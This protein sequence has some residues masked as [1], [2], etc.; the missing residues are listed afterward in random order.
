MLVCSR[1]A[2]AEGKFSDTRPAALS[3]S[4]LTMQVT[5]QDQQ[6]NEGGRTRGTRTVKQGRQG[7]ASC[8]EWGGRL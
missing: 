6:A 8:P 4:W 1:G 3:S 2:N 5:P 7:G